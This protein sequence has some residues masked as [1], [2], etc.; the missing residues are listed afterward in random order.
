MPKHMEDS[1]D[2]PLSKVLPIIQK[3]IMNQTTYLGIKTLKSPMDA[4][5]YQQIIFETEPDVIIEIG[6]AHGGSALFLAHICDNIGRGRVIGIDLS[7]KHVPEKVKQHPRITLIQGDACENFEKVKQLISIEERVLVIEDSLHT[8]EN[9]LNVLRL[10]S[11]LIKIGDY[12]IVE[13]SILHHG[14]S[15]GPKPGPYQAIETFLIEN[16]NFISDR[17]REHFFL[18]WNPK[19]YLKRTMLKGNKSKANLVDKVQLIKADRLAITDTIKLFIPPI[20]LQLIRKVFRI[21]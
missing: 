11:Q 2:I 7:H 1:L 16:E 12:F 5:V 20:L 18:T 15:L 14:L 6:N 3:G 10:Y 9:T 4:W 19:G 8:Y 17:S 21:H 13:D